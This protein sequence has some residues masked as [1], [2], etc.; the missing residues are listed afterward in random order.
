[1]IPL[2]SPFLG[3][4]APRGQFLGQISYEYSHGGGTGHTRM[5]SYLFRAKDRCKIHGQT[6]NCGLFGGSTRENAP[7]ILDDTF[8]AE[9]SP[10]TPLELV[11]LQPIYLIAS[12]LEE[13][14]EIF[15]YNV[16]F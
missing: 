15:V 12:A 5:D 10:A 14:P 16:N 4:F 1:M 2:Y 6:T 9:P 11:L 3:E 13:F 8:C 7:H